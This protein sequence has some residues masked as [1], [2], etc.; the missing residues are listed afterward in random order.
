MD[1]FEIHMMKHPWNGCEDARP[2][3]IVDF[4]PGRNVVGCFPIATQCYGGQCFYISENDPDFESTG[5]AHSSN[6]I[7]EKIIEIS[8]DRIIKRKGEL[9]GQM[10]ANFRNYSGI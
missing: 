9:T 7:D 2:W 1:I 8:T 6:V 10:L 3:L 4:P 5:L